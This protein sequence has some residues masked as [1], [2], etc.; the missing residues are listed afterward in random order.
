[1]KILSE[2]IDSQFWNEP[3][4]IFSYAYGKKQGSFSEMLKYY[5][6]HSSVSRYIAEDMENSLN[7]NLSINGYTLFNAY[8]VDTENSW[9]RVVNP[10]LSSAYGESPFFVVCDSNGRIIEHV[11]SFE[12]FVD[13]AAP[14][15]E[16][17]SCKLNYWDDAMKKYFNEN[18]HLDPYFEAQRDYDLTVWQGSGGYGKLYRV[19]KD[20]NGAA[21]YVDVNNTY[22]KLFDTEKD[23]INFLRGDHA[24]FVG[25]DSENDW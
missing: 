9:P 10:L 4:G 23:L 20:F 1:M 11:S 8:P 25:V 16:I 18:P 19:R 7:K 6:T 21:F 22:D 24:I 14:E 5:T 12:Q 13:I 3:S 17:T 2:S 15:S